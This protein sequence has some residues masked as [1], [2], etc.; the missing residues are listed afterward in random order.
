MIFWHNFSQLFLLRQL[1][2]TFASKFLLTQHRSWLEM[3]Q[4]LFLM[5]DISIS[6]QITRN[7]SNHSRRISTVSPSLSINYFEKLRVHTVAEIEPVTAKM[8]ACQAF[9]C[10]EMGTEDKCGVQL[11]HFTCLPHMLSNT[12]VRYRQALQQDRFVRLVARAS[13]H[14]RLF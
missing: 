4:G 12:L 1:R 14:C 7:P 11:P 13:V 9:E 6:V 10:R 5:T 8:R 2:K 3:G